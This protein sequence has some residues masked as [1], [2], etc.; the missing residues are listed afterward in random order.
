MLLPNENI[1]DCHLTLSR[2]VLCID[3]HV[4]IISNV[5]CINK[6]KEICDQTK[7]IGVVIDVRTNM[8]AKYKIFKNCSKNFI[9]ICKKKY[10]CQSRI[11][12][13][14]RYKGMNMANKLKYFWL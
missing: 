9:A 5:A 10:D 7:Y 14:H 2:L 6:G 11:A 8:A 13:G 12:R 4:F 1:C 3:T